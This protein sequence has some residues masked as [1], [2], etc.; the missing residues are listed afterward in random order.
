MSDEVIDLKE[1]LERVQDDREL[2][3]ELFDIFIE[4]YPGKLGAIKQATAKKDFEA[5]RDAAHSMKGASGNLSAKK[6]YAHFLKVEQLAKT[7]N[8]DGMESLL[9]EIERA[10]SDF[11]DYAAK[12][13]ADFK[14]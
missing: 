4:D 10:F 12:F 2:L 7:N 1:V 8:M 14:K 3:L 6:L 11:K 13:K 9:A 5:L